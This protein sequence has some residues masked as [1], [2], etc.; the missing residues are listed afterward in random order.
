[1]LFQLF[2]LSCVILGAFLVT[3]IGSSAVY[4][5]INDQEWSDG[6]AIVAGLLGVVIAMIWLMYKQVNKDAK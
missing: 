3:A 5:I 6:P 4:T 2:K 1:M